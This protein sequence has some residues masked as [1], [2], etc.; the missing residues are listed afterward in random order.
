MVLTRFYE[1]K[2]RF[3]K[4]RVTRSFQAQKG[5]LYETPKDRLYQTQKLSH[6]QNGSGSIE[7]LLA[8][9]IILLLGMGC[10][11]AGLLLSA[12]LAINHAAQE[13][14]RAGSVANADQAAIELGLARGLVPW[15][16]GSTDY[17]NFVE[18]QVKA[19]GYLAQGQAEGWV[20]VQQ[21]SP[22]KASFDDWAVAA[23]DENG[24]P[25]P[26]VLEIPNDNLHIYKQIRQARSGSSIKRGDEVI[27]SS[28]GQTLLDAN[29]LKLSFTVGVPVSVP[30]VGPMLVWTLKAYHG[31]ETPTKRR[32]G[33]V[34]LGAPKVLPSPE[35]SKCAVLALNQGVARVPILA[36]VTIGMQTAARASGLV[37]AKSQ[38]VNQVAS[39][40]N[41]SV[42]A[43]S[44]LKPPSAFN[45]AGQ[46]VGASVINRPNGYSQIGGPEPI[47]GGESGHGCPG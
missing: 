30:I 4:T 26:D 9:P 25:L 16:Y 45:S 2:S 38:S 5:R 46:G 1:Q 6:I 18:N 33:L 23:V 21:L 20:T 29:T 39:L 43:S 28:S 22:T 11:Q 42:D 27:G 7:L 32:V 10:V 13:A 15:L 17:T 36:E 31:C 41:S 19:V 47:V 35:A 44:V 12:K 40:G 37:A 34:D 14:G 24:E 3:F 8:L